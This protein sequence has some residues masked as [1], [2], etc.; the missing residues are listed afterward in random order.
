MDENWQTHREAE[1]FEE[2]VGKQHASLFCYLGFGRPFPFEWADRLKRRGIIPHIAWEPTSLLWVDEP[3]VERFAGELARFDAPVFIR[4]AGEMNGDWTPYHDDPK[5]YRETFRMV[6]RIISRRAPKAALIWCVNTIPEGNIDAYYP[7]DDAVDWVGVNMYNV[8]FFDNDPARP[9]DH[10]HPADLLA[11]VYKKYSKKKPIAICEYA[12]SHQSA[13]DQKAR[14]ELAITKIAQL[15]SALPRL[16]PRVKLVDWFDCD[17][18]KHARAGRQLN[19]Y[20]LTENAA[21]QDAYR[22]AVSTEHYL[23]RAEERPSEEL[24][25]L[26]GDTVRGVVKLSAWIRAPIEKPKVYIVA[27]DRV[28]YAGDQPETVACRWDTRKHANGKVMLRLL[29]LDRQ[30]RPV[31]EQ[32]QVVV[33]EN[34]PRN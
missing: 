1:E 5:T 21:I 16:Y 24:R 14:P 23:G 17:N 29:V 13:V 4:F 12:A 26:K 9:A 25:P 8:P 20:S 30:N 18:L 27:G 7:G 34:S 2:R 19:N 11:H 3:S 6:H 28:L 15:Y 10:V 31:H 33:V 22:R 32:K